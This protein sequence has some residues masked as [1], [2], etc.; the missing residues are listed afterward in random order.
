MNTDLLNNGHL[1]I[2][3]TILV[4]LYFISVS[5]KTND[6]GLKNDLWTISQGEGENIKERRREFSGQLKS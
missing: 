6:K 1:N 3:C 5:I 4:R 2:A